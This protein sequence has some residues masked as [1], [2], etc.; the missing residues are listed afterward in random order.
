MCKEQLKLIVPLKSP[1]VSWAVETAAPILLCAAASW[2]ILFQRDEYVLL[3]AELK[4]K[5]PGLN[6]MWHF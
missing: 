1:G 6:S 4:F 3:I 2:T 5:T